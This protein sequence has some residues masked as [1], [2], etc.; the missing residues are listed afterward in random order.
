MKINAALDCNRRI[1]T[2]KRMLNAR[3]K[4]PKYT[5]VKELTFIHESSALST[6]YPGCHG[7]V[8]HTTLATVFGSTARIIPARNQTRMSPWSGHPCP[9][10]IVGSMSIFL[11]VYVLLGLS[12]P[13]SVFPYVYIPP[14]LCSPR[15]MFPRVCFPPGLYSQVRIRG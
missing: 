5:H 2:V 8:Q 7:P 1:Q 4:L 3:L 6:S 12:S 9:H 15:S 13:R 14:C 11:Q 10:V